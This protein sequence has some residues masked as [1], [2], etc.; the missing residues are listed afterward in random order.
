M[1]QVT[2]DTT[3]DFVQI[4]RSVG[5]IRMSNADV[6]AVAGRRAI[7]FFTPSQSLNA[8]LPAD[9]AEI[10]STHL[11]S[12]ADLQ[13]EVKDAWSIENL[14]LATTSNINGTY[15]VMIVVAVAIQAGPGINRSHDVITLTNIQGSMPD[16]LGWR[17]TGQRLQLKSRT[18]VQMRLS[19]RIL[20]MV[21]EHDDGNNQTM[22]AR[23]SNVSSANE[24]FSTFQFDDLE[25]I[26]VQK[27]SVKGSFLSMDLTVW[28]EPRN[29]ELG[30]AIFCDQVGML[31]FFTMETRGWEYRGIADRVE[32]PSTG[33]IPRA[34]TFSSSGHA[35]AV[36]GTTTSTPTR[37][38]VS[39]F[40]FGTD[41]V[42]VPLKAFLVTV[43]ELPTEMNL[44]WGDRLVM[45]SFPF[46]LDG[47]GIVRV[48]QGVIVK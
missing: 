39:F 23:P 35:V 18:N 37:V 3:G 14:A 31:H 47:H 32:I 34:V 29:G 16:S 26:W 28:T 40:E 43:S 44:V 22:L 30:R 1:K 27:G 46:S 25:S 8:I 11:F 15:G 13:R 6:F 12:D 33:I 21:S 9:L 41:G 24:G 20:A 42:L 36:L 17:T 19:H 38:I 10:N 45:V 4:G 48:Y 7:R 5:S 2:G